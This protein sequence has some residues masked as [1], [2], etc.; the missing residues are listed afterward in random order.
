MAVRHGSLIEEELIVLLCIVRSHFVFF[1]FEAP[2]VLW[3]KGRLCQSHYSGILF[4]E[5][6]PFWEFV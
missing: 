4:L 1:C 5:L 6:N 3:M 2:W